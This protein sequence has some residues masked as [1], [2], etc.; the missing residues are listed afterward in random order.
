MLTSSTTP[1]DATFY[2]TDGE[3]LDDAWPRELL[4]GST[5]PLSGERAR[6]KIARV[7]AQR[8]GEAVDLVEGDILASL[9]AAEVLDALIEPL[10]HSLLREA[11][12]TAVRA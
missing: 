12:R 8:H 1:R 5:L 11:E 3:Q 6:E 4:A 9:Q 2:D 7:D 10:G